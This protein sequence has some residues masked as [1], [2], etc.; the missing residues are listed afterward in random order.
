MA[1]I[2]YTPRSKG[3][4]KGAADAKKIALTDEQSL[5]NACDAPLVVVNAYA[6]S[7][8]TTLLDAYSR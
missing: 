7:G 8:K 4:G 3:G 6:G 2:P 5:V 1:M